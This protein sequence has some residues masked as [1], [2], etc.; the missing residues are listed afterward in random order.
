MGR[1]YK[2][3]RVL[4]EFVKIKTDR[5]QLCEFLEQTKPVQSYKQSSIQLTWEDQLNLSHFPFMPLEIIS[6][7]FP[8]LI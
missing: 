5:D 2:E 3:R 7:N 6:K 1:E 8:K 4:L